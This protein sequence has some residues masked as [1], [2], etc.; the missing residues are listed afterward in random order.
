MHKAEH[1]RCLIQFLMGLN[2]IY[3]I[4]R[5]S[6][7]MMKPLPSL[8][9]VFSLLIQEEKQREF[10]PSNQLN[11]ESTSLHVNATPT[12]HQSPFGARNFKTHYTS[13][14]RGLPFCDYCKRPGHTKE[15]YYKLHGGKGVVA[16]VHG[17][18]TDFLHEREDD[19]VAHDENQNVN[20]TREQTALSN[21]TTLP[22]T[23]LISLPNGYRVK[24]PLVKR[25]QVIGSSSEELYYMCSRCLK[26]K[27]T[28]SNLDVSGSC[29]NYFSTT[30]V[31]SEGCRSPTH[32]YHL[33]SNVNTFTHNNKNESS[34]VF[35]KYDVNLLW[36][37]RL[38]H[39]PFVKMKR[40][41][42]ILVPFSPQTTIYLFNLPHS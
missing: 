38:G 2:E 32:S 10:S 4:V 33:S 31:N 27:S 23:L 41:S 34:V 19:S 13:N 5:G 7:L 12:Q 11:L 30:S 17:V 24:A 40:I 37:N 1:D 29:C 21:I 15:K 3:T 18:P 16:N 26:G 14:N 22:Y 20:L 25:P 39:V 28:F 36:H 35:D 42:S 8:A 9:Q 6:I